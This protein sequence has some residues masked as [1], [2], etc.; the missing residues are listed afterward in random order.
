M[1]K[2]GVKKNGAV[3]PVSNK[4]KSILNNEGIAKLASMVANSQSLQR[5]VLRML[6]NPG[7][8]INW[9]CGYPDNILL[10]DYKKMY[11]REGLGTRIVKLFPEESWAMLPTLYENEETENT[12]FE[13]EWKDLQERLNVFSYLQRVDVLSGIGSYGILLLGLNSGKLHQPAPMLVDGKAKKSAKKLELM[14]LRAFDESVITIKEKEKD[15]SSPRFNSPIL[16]EIK[17]NE[18]TK[19]GE[20][21]N[22]VVHWS[23]V[24]HVADNRDSSEIYGIPRMQP[25]Y[26]RLL[27]LR[28]IVAGSG[29]MFWKGG[30]PGM[31][32]ETHPEAGDSSLTTDELEDLREQFETYQAGLQR[33]L[34][35]TGMTAKSLTP[36]V[37]DPKGHMEANLRYIAITVGIPLRILLGTEEAK[38]ASS[39]DV[40]TWNKRLSKRQKSYI[41]PMLIKPFVERLQQL[42]VLSLI[43]KYNISWPDLNAPSD[44]EQAE[45]INKKTDALSKYVLGNVDAM[46]PPEVFLKIF[47]DLD[48]NQIEVIRKAAQHWNDTPLKQ[49]GMPENQPTPQPKA[50]DNRI[51][52]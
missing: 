12:T 7:K 50:K 44:E 31:A 5:E 3:A 47:M 17:L 42:Q 24:I 19:V 35:I 26:N 20:L 48:E 9:E 33:Y 39:Q 40:R 4:E 15:T 11:D 30:F 14:Y 46:I 2:K 23:R 22:I 18:N 34:A 32:F 16:Y 21:Q 28:K 49:V 38:L 43:E 13:K 51:T 36:Q 25:V 1:A 6:L 52:S 45:I 29:E 41:E 37:A 10:A 27:D 8:D